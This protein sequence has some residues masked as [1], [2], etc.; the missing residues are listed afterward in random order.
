ML[1]H[2]TQAFAAVSL[3]LST[4]ASIPAWPESPLAGT[5]DQ[6][7]P[8]KARLHA[9]A[10]TKVAIRRVVIVTPRQPPDVQ[11]ISFGP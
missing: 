4:Q 2:F 6:N 9:T 5:A 7:C 8:E 11:V 10:S 1:S 3:L